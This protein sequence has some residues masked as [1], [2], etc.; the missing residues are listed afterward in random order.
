MGWDAP[1]GPDGVE[2]RGR[3]TRRL[4]LSRKENF[5]SAASRDGMVASAKAGFRKD[6]K[7][8][9]YEVRF[10][11]DAGAY[12]DYTVNVSRTMGY[13]AE[14]VSRIFPTSILSLL[15]S[16]PTRFPPRR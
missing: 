8:T 7:C 12:A 16:T 4:L 14:G 2:G 13:A 15:L 1:L 9:A 10:V 5:A 3:E 11:V 6:G